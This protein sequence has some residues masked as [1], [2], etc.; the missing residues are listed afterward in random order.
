[1]AKMT[2]RS[3]WAVARTAFLKGSPSWSLHIVVSETVELDDP[4]GHKPDYPSE[5]TV[6]T[7][8]DPALPIMLAGLVNS[9]IQ[10]PPWQSAFC[11]F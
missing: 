11:D 3:L 6:P 5:M 7:L 1:M 4:D 10:S 8:G 9:R 2:L